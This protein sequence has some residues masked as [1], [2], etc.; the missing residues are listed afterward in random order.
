LRILV[1]SGEY[2]PMKGGVGRYTYNLVNALKKRNN[3]EIFIAMSNR[4]NKT[5]T[6]TATSSSSISSD[7]HS[8][9]SNGIYY[10]I[11]N[12]G[13][14][15]NSDRL[16]NLIDKL[17]PD[18]VNIQYERGLYEI[19][20]T[21]R[22]MARRLLY[23]STLDKFY[24]L[25]PVPTV[26][27]LHTV[28]PYN[29]YQEYIKELALKK[30]GRFAALP[31][32]LRA[33]IRR[34]VLEKRYKLLLEIVNLSKEIISL[35]KSNQSLVKRGTVIYHG[36]ESAPSL[37]AK[38]K[39][40]Y[41]REFGLPTSNR[42]LLAFGYVGSYKGFDIL[43]NLNLPDEWSLVIKQNKHERG[44]EQPV[45]IKNAI[46]LHLGYLDDLTLSKLFFACD[47]IIFP[48]RVVSISG[49]LFDALAHGLPFIASDLSFFQEFAQMELGITCRRNAKSFS[50]SLIGL[51][52]DYEKYHNNVLQFNPKLKWDNIAN[53]Y[54][55]FFSKLLNS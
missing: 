41:R 43:S 20:T 19:D 46:N 44:K 42:L 29:E 55:D 45:H 15:Q 35:A 49:V 48:Y 7:S 38:N 32:P 25:C 33:A 9:F 8:Y 5:T 27:T 16:L 24:K 3:I 23:G 13:D 39:Q 2:P 30:V 21:I 26:S 37:S 53:N 1:V 31:T 50:E 28:L 18:I 6:T 54:I 34:V 47:A 11:V 12:K 22:H 10:D 40:E 52:T 17:K 36:A 51:A 4:N 14:K